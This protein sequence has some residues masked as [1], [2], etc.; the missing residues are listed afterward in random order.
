MENSE[1]DW[2]SKLK[3]KIKIKGEKYY[4]KNYD[5]WCTTIRKLY[6]R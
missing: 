5:Y 6:A 1:W 2:K 4:E 3:E